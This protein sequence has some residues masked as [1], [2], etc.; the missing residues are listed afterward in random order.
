MIA[1][2]DCANHTG[3]GLQNIFIYVNTSTKTVI[4][5]LNNSMYVPFSEIRHRKI[6]L[7][8][9]NGYHYLI[10]AHFAEYVDNRSNTNTYL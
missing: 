5:K 10:R 2:V 6:Q 7:M 8:T 3:K 9:E 1:M 4:S